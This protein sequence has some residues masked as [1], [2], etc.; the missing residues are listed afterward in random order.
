MVE[1]GRDGDVKLSSRGSTTIV[2][3]LFVLFVNQGI[4]YYVQRFSVGGDLLGPWPVF[5]A[6][7][8]ASGLALGSK[9]IGVKFVRVS[10][11]CFGM[12]V[13]FAAT[14]AYSPSGEYGLNKTLLTLL[15]PAVCMLAG[16]V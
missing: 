15:V 8:A 10:L 14:Y 12:C 4:V 7:I 3:I 11:T 9:M 16:F 5:L 13:L 2:A 6:T 1:S